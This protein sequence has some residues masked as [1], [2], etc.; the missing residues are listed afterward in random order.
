MHVKASIDAGEIFAIFSSID[1]LTGLPPIVDIGF[2]P[3]EPEKEESVVK[4]GKGRGLGHI[5]Y[6]VYP[7]PNTPSGIS[8][9]N[10]ATI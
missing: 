4:P 7:K 6:A 10:V 9:R 2:L 3:P 1:P 8:I 5:S